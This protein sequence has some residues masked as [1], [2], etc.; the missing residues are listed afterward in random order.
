MAKNGHLSG[1]I[2]NFYEKVLLTSL[3]RVSMHFETFAIFLVFWH[4]FHI[5]NSLYLIVKSRRISPTT[6]IQEKTIDLRFLIKFGLYK[7]TY[8]K[9]ER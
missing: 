3:I 6:Y 7:L 8:T 9:L 2:L 5:D 4:F 1:R